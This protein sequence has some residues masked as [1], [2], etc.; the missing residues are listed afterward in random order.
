MRPN[1]TASKNQSEPDPDY[2]GLRVCI[3]EALDEYFAN[4]DGEPPGGKLYY[5]VVAEVEQALLGRILSETGG[6]QRQAAEFLGLN[7]NTLRKKVQEH[8]LSLGD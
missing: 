7:R 5:L 6:N 1:V 8:G 2:P 4:L 3:E